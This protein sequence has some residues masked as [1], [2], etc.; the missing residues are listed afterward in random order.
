MADLDTVRAWLER[1]A[2]VVAANLGPRELVAWTEDIAPMLAIRFDARAFTFQ[3]LEN[4]AAESKYL[5]AY[6]EIVERLNQWTKDQPTP[7]QIANQTNT[8]RLSPEDQVC[9]TTWIK[10]RNNGDITNLANSLDMLRCHQPNAFAHLSAN[11]Q[12]C[13]QIA[14]QRNWTTTDDARNDWADLTEISLTRKLIDIEKTSRNSPPIAAAQLALL[15]S[16]VAKY[17]PQ[18]QHILPTQFSQP[19]QKTNSIAEQLHAFGINTPTVLT[20]AEQ[21]QHS[22]GRKPGELTPEQLDAVNPLPNGRKRV[23]Q[24]A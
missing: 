15:K 1:F 23:R 20:A 19:E 21:F 3:S 24:P 8:A 14:N 16:A 4:I 9:I 7:K 11:D 13:K 2:R 6:A 22:H 12:Q 5:P 17:A 10:R 18:L